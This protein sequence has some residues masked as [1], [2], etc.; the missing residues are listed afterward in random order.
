MDLGVATI[1]VEK[2][3]VSKTWIMD[4]TKE[5]TIAIPVKCDVKLI[6]SDVA[7]QN[8]EKREN[9]PGGNITG[10]VQNNSRTSLTKD[11]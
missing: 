6:L 8:V 5:L 10:V 11:E 9:V 2:T 4:I 1:T 7:E 3:E